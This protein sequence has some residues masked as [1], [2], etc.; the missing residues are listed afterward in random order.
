MYWIIWVIQPPLSSPFP[1]MS[2]IPD[3]YPSCSTSPSY[4]AKFYTSRS[5]S[6]VSWYVCSKNLL[7]CRLYADLLAQTEPTGW[8]FCWPFKCCY[9]YTLNPVWFRWRRYLQYVHTHDI[10]KKTKLFLSV[11]NICTIDFDYRFSFSFLDSPVWRLALLA[12]PKMYCTDQNPILAISQP[13][14]KRKT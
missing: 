3:L 5:V 2:L 13:A 9:K 14:K 10:I 11:E 1:V 8:V 4:L 7:L 6:I 12:Q